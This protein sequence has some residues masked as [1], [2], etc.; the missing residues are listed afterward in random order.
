YWM[1]R[2]A[3]KDSKEPGIDGGLLRRPK[4]CKAPEKGQAVTGYVCTIVVENID[5]TI[6]QLESEGCICAVPKMAL[7]GMAW[8]AYYLDTEKNVFGL[9][10]PDKNAK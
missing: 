4:D 2:T 9:H 1:I 3:P 6:R 7:P 10:Q 8:Q 5:E